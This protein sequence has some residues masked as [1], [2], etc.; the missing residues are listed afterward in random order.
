MTFKVVQM[1]SFLWSKIYECKII[2]DI[3]Y[4]FCNICIFGFKVSGEL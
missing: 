3:V 2:A 4:T 1:W